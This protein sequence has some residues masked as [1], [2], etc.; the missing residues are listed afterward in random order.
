[1]TKIFTVYDSKTEAYLTPIFL[2]A[3]GQAVREV[4]ELANNAEHIFSKHSS[5]F[6]LFE[7]GTYDEQTGLI[8]NLKA[9]INL[10]CLVTFREQPPLRA[11]ER[12][13]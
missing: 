11:L 9:P 6:T 4:S 2:K 10:G 7:I 1:M 12:A 3:T 13:N 5:D 8:E